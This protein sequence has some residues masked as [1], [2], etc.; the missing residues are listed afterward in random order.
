MMILVMMM[1]GLETMIM[2]MIMKKMMNLM[3]RK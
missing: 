3:G 1:I 2:T